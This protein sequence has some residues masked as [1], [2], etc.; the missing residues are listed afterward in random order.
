L[1]NVRPL[2]VKG[3]NSSGLAMLYLLF[4]FYDFIYVKGRNTSPL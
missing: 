3:S 1:G 4:Y 2:S